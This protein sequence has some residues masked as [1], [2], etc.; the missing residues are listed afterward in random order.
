M[1]RADPAEPVPRM[2][3]RP[4]PP[5]SGTRARAFG[6]A[7]R[8]EPDPILSPPRYA[9]LNTNSKNRSPVF[10]LMDISCLPCCAE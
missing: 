4:L 2:P 6:I 8:Q 3:A 7:S 1:P 5:K 10:M 9:C